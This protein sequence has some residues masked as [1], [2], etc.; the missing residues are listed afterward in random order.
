VLELPPESREKELVLLDPLRD[1]GF[2]NPFSPPDSMRPPRPQGLYREPLLA[3]GLGVVLGVAVFSVRNAFSEAKL[4]TDARAADTTQAYQ[5]YLARGGKR[6]DVGDVLLPRA[7][8]RDAQQRGGVEAIEEYVASHP[9]SKIPHEVQAALKASLLTALE[10][11]KKKNTLAA[12][13]EFEARYGKHGLVE[14]EVEKARRDH[15]SR[16]LEAFRKQSNGDPELVAFAQ[17][18]LERG[19]KQ[20]SRVLVGFRRRLPSTLEDSQKVLVKSS[21]YAGDATLPG[22]FF[23]AKSSEV[24]EERYGR[25]IVERLQ[26][27]FPVELARFELAPTSEDASEDVPK[28]DVPTLLFTYRHELSGAYMSRKPRA[29]FAG[30]GLFVRA[31]FLLPGEAQDLSFK[32]TGWLAPD[33]K[34]IEAGELELPHVYDDMTEKAFRKFLKKYWATWFRE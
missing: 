21:Y 34:R 29:A 6:E 33:V 25:E 16:V 5:D 15:L 22:K 9:N 23:D 14:A 3:L 18:L 27:L 32:H 20:G 28:V 24:R 4:Y 7:E 31:N 2:K 1:N 19:A 17:K 26:S 12:L 11:A 10:E 30:V 8:L 13:N